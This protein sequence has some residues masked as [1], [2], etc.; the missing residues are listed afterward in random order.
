ML[1]GTSRS[2]GWRENWRGQ[3][4]PAAGI[5]SVRDGE[6]HLVLSAGFHN[7]THKHADELGFELSEGG[8]RLV[9]DTGMPQ[10]PPAIRDFVVSWLARTAR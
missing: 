6:S 8:R 10:G 4:L 5:A 3:R 1:Q 7:T 2:C 9:T